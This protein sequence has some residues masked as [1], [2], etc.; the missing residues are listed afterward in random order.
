MCEPRATNTVCGRADEEVSARPSGGTVGSH[1]STPEITQESAS[2]RSPHAMAVRPSP[3]L[4]GREASYENKEQGERAPVCG[5][6]V[7]ASTCMCSESDISLAALLAQGLSRCG[8]SSQP[9]C[10]ADL[11]SLL[12]STETQGGR[13]PGQRSCELRALS[14]LVLSSLGLLLCH[15]VLL[16][17]WQTL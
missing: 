16:A 7:H 10:P 4:Y 8:Y 11:L 5:A 2:P 17:A 14:G 1:R 15:P 6:C 3:S 9:V 12:P 13:H